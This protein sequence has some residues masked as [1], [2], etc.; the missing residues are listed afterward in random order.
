MS[1]KNKQQFDFLNPKQSSSGETEVE[2]KVQKKN[3]RRDS[4]LAENRSFL[5]FL[6]RFWEEKFF[7]TEDVVFEPLRKNPYDLSYSCLLIPRFPGHQLVGDVVLGLHDRMMQICVSYGWRLDYVSVQ[8]DYMEWVAS[9]PPA[10]PTKRLMDIIRKQTSQYLFENFPRFARTNPSGEFWAP[11]Y[12]INIGSQNHSISV[13][14]Q[15]ILETR[16]EQGLL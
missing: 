10:T 4:K 14:N 3:N 15:F 5:Q 7:S 2:E 16:R 12:L 13:I 9:V 11:G 8:K 1:D 6:F